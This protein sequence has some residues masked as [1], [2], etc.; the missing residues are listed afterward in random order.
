MVLFQVL[1][2]LPSWCCCASRLLGLVVFLLF[3][4]GHLSQVWSSL[5]TGRCWSFTL[6]SSSLA[7][8]RG[9]P[10][11]VFLLLC[12]PSGCGHPL[13]LLVSF[14]TIDRQRRLPLEGFFLCVVASHFVVL[15]WFPYVLCQFVMAPR[16]WWQR[17]SLAYH[18]SS[19]YPSSPGF[20]RG[21]G[22]ATHMVVCTLA[23]GPR[24]SYASWLSF[25]LHQALGLLVPVAT[26]LH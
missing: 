8:L 7:W 15:S 3:L 20:A 26:L 11:T 16:G 21:L 10:S 14:V 13:G 23:V 5:L 24:V 12:L 19:R 25:A 2:G 17:F 22:C 1:V 4:L 9:E 18:C 6:D